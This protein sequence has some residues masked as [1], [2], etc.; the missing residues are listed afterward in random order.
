MYK[1]KKTLFYN[2]EILL[3]DFWESLIYDEEERES[4]KVIIVLPGVEEIP[5]YT[6]R[7]CKNLETV[8]MSDT[9]RWIEWGAFFWCYSAFYY[10]EAL[11]SIFIPPSC[12]E[13]DREAFLNCEKLKIFHVSQQTEL[14]DSI[15][16]NTALIKASRFETD[17][18]DYYQNHDDEVNEWIKNLNQDEE[19]ALNRECASYEPSDDNIYEIIKQQGL[20]SIH[21]K[22]QIGLTAFE[23]LHKN[24]YFTSR[25]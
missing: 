6:F 14:G 11:V 10:C 20:S 8:I 4:W 21:V 2:G 17:E 24:P 13:I 12:R 5:F 23:Y 7:G 22:N 19:F 9:V 25:N 16:A 18:Y 15:I 1:D 3:D